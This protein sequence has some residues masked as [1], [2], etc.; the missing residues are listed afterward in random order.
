[1]NTLR[2]PTSDD[3]LLRWWLHMHPLYEQFGTIKG[4][5]NG[6]YQITMNDP[7]CG[8][9]KRSKQI[10]NSLQHYWAPARIYLIRDVDEESGEL[11]SAEVLACVVDG[12]R[13]DP[14]AE[15]TWLAGQPI[16]ESA[17]LRLESERLA[18]L[19]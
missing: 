5:T 16:S 8:F 7:Q 2:Q 11:L 9:F 12:I 15:W 13:K 17:Y 4:H 6:R 14:I 18:K 19:F 10:Y 1:M 3:V